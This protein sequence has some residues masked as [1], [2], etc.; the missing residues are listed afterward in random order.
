MSTESL[1]KPGSV[2][3]QIVLLGAILTLGN[4]AQIIHR[5][6]RVFLF[7]QAQCLIYYK[8]A[9]PS[10]IDAQ[11]QVDE[12][13]CKLG[14]IQSRL[15]MID[16]VDASDISVPVWF[17]PDWATAAALLSFLFALIGGGGVVRTIIIVKCIADIA[18]PESL[19][20]SYN[21][22]TAF[23]TLGSVVGSYIGS[24]LLSHHVYVQNFISV[25]CYILTVGVAAFIPSYL[26]FEQPAAESAALID[27]DDDDEHS[28]SPSRLDY[29]R[30]RLFDT[31]PSLPTLLLHSLTSTYHTLT[32]LLTTPRPISTILLIYLLYG[33]ASRTEVLLPQYTSLLLAWPLAYVNKILALKSLVS[34][35][36]LFALPSF[37]TIYLQP[38]MST[39]EID[40]LI[41]KASLVANGVGVVGMGF[42]APNAAFFI[43]ALCVYTSG[44]GLADS[45]VA[46]GTLLLPPGPRVAEFYVWTGLID[47]LATL[48][49][50]PAWSA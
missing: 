42:H 18:P 33:L 25:V 28:P 23:Y 27:E 9:D 45:L 31:K 22:V 11:F 17:H 39:P 1:K 24:L 44:I 32:T 30:T 4:L 19:A 46:Y 26:G 8:L 35:C 34:A 47:T 50:A 36:I 38:R 16:G 49:G 40:L 43:G 3:S 29:S 14:P 20:K 12:A 6:S 10:K 5:S 41:T 7:Q 21:Y 48:I 2:I 13:L 37:R 15:S